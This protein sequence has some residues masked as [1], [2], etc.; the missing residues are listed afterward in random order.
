[1]HIAESKDKI[2]E[3]HKKLEHVLRGHVYSVVELIIMIVD[4]I[5]F[6]QKPLYL[7]IHN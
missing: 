4:Q 6:F 2:E 1:M 7:L 3:L 5:V